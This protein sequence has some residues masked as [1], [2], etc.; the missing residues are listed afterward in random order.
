MKEFNKSKKLEH[1]L[2]DIRGPVLDEAMRLEKEGHRIIK[3]NTGNPA[4][5][6]LFAPDQVLEDVI[7]NL[8]KAQGYS[9]SK[10][11]YSARRAI[12]IYTE[13]VG[14]QN[15]DVE[16]IYI[17]NGVSELIVMAMQGLLDRGDEILLPAPDYPLWTAAV[18]LSGGNPVHY[19]CDEAS[20]WA[21]DVEDIRKKITDKTKGIV[22]I[23]P[24]N[25]TGAVYSKQLLM[26]LIQ[27]ARE[28]Q[29]IVFSDEIY[30]RILYDG[31]VHYPTASLADDLLIITL[32]GLSKSH[33]I[34]GFRVGWM[35]ISGNKS[36]AQDYIDGLNMLANMRLCSN[37]PAQFAVQA[38][39]GD[40]ESIQQ[41]TRPG[42]RL[43]DQRNYAYDHVI[44]L[45]GFSCVKPK[46]AFYLFP[47]FDT[48]KYNIKSDVKF[49][50]DILTEKHIL[51]VQGTGFN[52]PS[53]D[54]LRVVFL[55]P[56][57]DLKT[58]FTDISDF[59]AG[60]KQA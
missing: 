52:W 12:Q 32:N 59:L 8:D 4:P 39:L 57:E 56:L 35:T 41:L 2:Y 37:V 48:K 22:I 24:N 6:S 18:S 53:P 44:D 34:A 28:H 30:D 5:F 25:P 42:G 31:S 20:D 36:T 11:L 51:L 3:L 7:S 15:V 60:Y 26:D 50:Y 29:L 13:N 38:A 10:G 47:K 27:L 54:H 21:P 19:I 23:N 1:V 33:R 9:D 14:I 46:G 17:G 16:D 40:P 45:P 43:Y 58:V 49:I 55:P